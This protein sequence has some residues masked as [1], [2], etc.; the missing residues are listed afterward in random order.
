MPL[1]QKIGKAASLL[2]NENIGLSEYLVFAATV[3]PLEYSSGNAFEYGIVR[4]DNW[5]KI[6]PYQFIVQDT[7]TT[8]GEGYTKYIYTLP[9]PPDAMSVQM[10]SASGVTATLGGVVEEV[11]ENVFWNIQLSGTTGSAIGRPVISGL[12]PDTTISDT[13][14]VATH[15]RPALS[16]TGLLAGLGA[17]IQ[18]VVQGVSNVV[19]GAMPGSFQP[20]T[21]LA[22]VSGALSGLT[23]PPLPYSGSAVSS[24][25]NSSNGQMEILQLQRFLHAYSILKGESADRWRLWFVNNK[26]N[27]AFR[28]IISGGMTVQRSV[29][30]PYLY[31][32]KISMVG[33]GVTSSNLIAGEDAGK[34]LDR[35]Q[36]DLKTVNTLTLTGIANSTGKLVGTIMGGGK[37]IAGAL[38]VVPKVI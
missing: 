14:T 21:L 1:F 30:E 22:P 4:L 19:S 20:S 15:F 13:T 10:V 37:N 31:R 5:H 9:I 17:G 27:Q 32:Y 2:S 7:D 29:Q 26:D 6:Y 28:V 23:Q 33:W 8:T 18:T 35:F 16:T 12:E 24:G 25:G 34:P 3:Q 36:G 11:S 38:G